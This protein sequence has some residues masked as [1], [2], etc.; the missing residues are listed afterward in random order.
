M[1]SEMRSIARKIRGAE[2]RIRRY[3]PNRRRPG[4]RERIRYEI[5]SLRRLR[6]NRAEL[7]ASKGQ[8]E[9]Q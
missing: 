3:W 8:E 2:E 4:T 6:E 1:K 7:A 9:K 5:V